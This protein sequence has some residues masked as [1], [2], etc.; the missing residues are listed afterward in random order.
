[1][2][3]IIT[4]LQ[5]GLAA[6]ESNPVIS[7]YAEPIILAVITGSSK[8]VL[9]QGTIAISNNGAPIHFTIPQALVAIETFILTS[10]TSIQIG[11][12]LISWAPNSAVV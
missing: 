5:A 4:T 3:S 10:E 11:S 2:A 12:T 9:P 1:M 6:I 8:I 7:K